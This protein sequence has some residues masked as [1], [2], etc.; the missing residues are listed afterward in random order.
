MQ[1]NITRVNI[2]RYF[3]TEEGMKKL[4]KYIDNFSCPRNPSIERFLKRSAI[5]FT[6][7][8]TSV[9][10]L[11][12]SKN[13][14][15]LFGYFSITVRPIDVPADRVSKTLGRRLERAGR[16]DRENNVYNAAAYLIAQLGKNYT[17]GLNTRISGA[18]LLNTALRVL[19]LIQ[20]SVGGSI[21]FLEAENVPALI[22]FYTQNSFR[23]F[24]E[25]DSEEGRLIQFVKTI[26]LRK[27]VALTNSFCGTYLPQFHRPVH[28]P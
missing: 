27:S 26:P 24:G 13:E 12:L 20:Y 8:D 10:Y 25:R 21:V 22:D 17:D 4:Q 28:S 23:V 2:R 11:V 5:N 18:E 1:S 16:F 9:T 3:S 19:T 7:Q 15:E 14:E 6:K